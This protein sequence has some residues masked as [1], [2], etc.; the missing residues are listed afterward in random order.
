MTKMQDTFDHE[1]KN[2]TFEG[3]KKMI[4]ST[5]VGQNQISYTFKQSSLQ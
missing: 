2:T 5:C 3:S 1:G 4:F